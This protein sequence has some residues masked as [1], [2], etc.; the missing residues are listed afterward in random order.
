MAELKRI[1]VGVDGSGCSLVALR[2]AIEQARQH[3]SEI[4]AVNAWMPVPVV[5]PF[6]GVP[7][8]VDLQPAE[9]ARAVLDQALQEVGNETEIAIE[10]FVT[11]G[12][13]AKVLIDLSKKVNLVV[14]GTRGH[15]GFAGLL[16]GSVSQHVAAHSSCTVV[17]VRE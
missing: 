9:N 17:V 2:W 16:L 14:V 15:G 6:G 7:P 5:T 12:N 3:G 10:S 11:E 13:A 8:R 4:I 1:V